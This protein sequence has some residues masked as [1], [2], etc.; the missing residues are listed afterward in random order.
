MTAQWSITTYI[1]TYSYTG[2]QQ[3]WTVPYTGNYKVELWG[4]QSSDW[5]RGSYVAGNTSFAKG[6]SYYL[7]VGSRGTNSSVEG[8]EISGGYNG[9]GLAYGYSD[10]NAWSGGG[11][12]DIRTISGTWNNANSLRSRVMVAAGSG[13]GTGSGR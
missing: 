11:A 8:Q 1:Q 5:R 9:G 6:D 13:G 12:T 2:S 10:G 7:H 4:A 3:T